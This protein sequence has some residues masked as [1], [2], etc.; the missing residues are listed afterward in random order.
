MKD[1]PRGSKWLSCPN[2]WGKIGHEEGDF[3]IFSPFQ[4]ES[5]ND[6]V[7]L[8]HQ[9]PNGSMPKR[10]VANPFEEGSP[11]HATHHS[12]A[13]GGYSV[14]QLTRDRMSMKPWGFTVRL[15]EF[16]GA[17]LV[18]S[19]EPLSPAEA[20]VSDVVFVSLYS[21]FVCPYY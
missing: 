15:H 17:C 8:F 11:Y 6:I 13:R 9:G 1:D 7:S 2:P 20:A 18:D 4:S 10:F 21:S 16:G 12:P 19:I 3:V 5:A 14:L